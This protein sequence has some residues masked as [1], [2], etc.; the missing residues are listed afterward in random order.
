MFTT[1][2]A[3]RF[4]AAAFSVIISAGLLAYA[5]LPATPAVI[6]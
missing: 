5:I 4:I 6:A 1:N 2:L 3:D